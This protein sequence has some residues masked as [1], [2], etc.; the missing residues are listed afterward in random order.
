MVNLVICFVFIWDGDAEFSLSL[1]D[2][3]MLCICLGDVDFALVH[4]PL[5]EGATINMLQLG[6]CPRY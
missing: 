2:T 1:F 6:L 4:D 5:E 3:V